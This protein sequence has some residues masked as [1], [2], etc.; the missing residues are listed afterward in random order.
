LDVVDCLSWPGLLLN[1][2]FSSHAFGVR[3]SGIYQPPVARFATL[4]GG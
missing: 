1:R 4:T 2:Q 3:F